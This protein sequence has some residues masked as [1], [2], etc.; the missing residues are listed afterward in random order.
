LSHTPHHTKSPLSSRGRDN[1]V[2]V[3]MMPV[4]GRSIA[5]ACLANSCHVTTRVLNFSSVLNDVIVL[6]GFYSSWVCQASIPLYTTVQFSS[7]ILSLSRHR[8]YNLIICHLND[9]HLN[10]LHASFF[11]FLL[12]FGYVCLHMLLRCLPLRYVYVC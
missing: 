11:Y 9:I 10:L 7:V 12:A 4:C 5:E 3:C 8:S 1:T 6:V 2:F